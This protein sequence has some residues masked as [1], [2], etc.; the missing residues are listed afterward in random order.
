MR[1]RWHHGE[2]MHVMAR[3]AVW[4]AR[5]VVSGGDGSSG[6]GTAWQQQR[7]W[8]H[9]VRQLRDAHIMKHCRIESKMKMMS[10]QRLVMKRP[11]A[12]RSAGMSMKPTSTGVMMAVKMSAKD[13]SHDHLV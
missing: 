5:R 7:P 3:L 12:H 2:W 11:S 9:G 13:V 1:G 6:G 4:F 10:T 8:R